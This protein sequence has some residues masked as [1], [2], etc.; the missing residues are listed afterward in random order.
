MKTERIQMVTKSFS[1]LFC[2]FM[3]VLALLPAL[4]FAEAKPKLNEQL[5]QAA[6]K[7]DLAEVR[8]LLTKGANVNAKGAHGRTVL[9]EA[10]RA[11]RIEPT[12]RWA[13]ER[14]L[15]EMIGPFPAGYAPFDRPDLY[16]FTGIRWMTPVGLDDFRELLPSKDAFTNSGGILEDWTLIDSA[17][18]GY[19]DV[20]DLLL[21]KGA[22]INAKDHD[23]RT[24]LTFAV[25]KGHEPLVAQLVCCSGAEVNARDLDDRTALMEAAWAGHQGIA[26]WLVEWEAHVN[27]EDKYGKTALHSAVE[28]GHIDMAKLLLDK[29]ADVNAMQDDGWSA[30]RTAVMRDDV[31]MVELLRAHGANDMTLSI[32]AMLGDTKEI[33]RLLDA[34]ADVNA[35]KERGRTAFLWAAMAGKTEAVKLLLVK[36]AD[37]NSSSPTGTTALMH[38]VDNGQI[39]LVRLFLAKG[40]SVN[41]SDSEGMTA[42]MVAMRQPHLGIVNFL[43]E[44]GADVSLRNAGHRTAWQ[45]VC[46]RGHKEIEEAL[47]AEGAKV[48]P[49][50]VYI[51]RDGLNFVK[52]PQTVPV[53]G[54]PRPKSRHQ[55]IRLDF[56][57]VTI[58]P[59]SDD[60]EVDAVFH[61]LN[62]G[63]TTTEWIGFPFRDDTDSEIHWFTMWV[64]GRKVGVS[65]E[66]FCSYNGSVGSDNFLPG[67]RCFEQRLTFP[68][69][70]R[71]IVRVSYRAGYSNDFG[72]SMRYLYGTSSLWKGAIGRSVF[73]ID[74]SSIGG[75]RRIHARLKPKTPASKQTTRNAV[76]YEIRNFKPDPA[77]EITIAVKPAGWYV[78]CA[79]LAPRALERLSGERSQGPK[80]VS[81]K[82][83]SRVA[84]VGSVSLGSALSPF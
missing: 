77:S 12:S 70:K 19:L 46:S 40:A 72:V 21:D 43:L 59:G 14:S 5:I 29:G 26:T 51:A 53:C 17:G 47:K 23:G 18:S 9:M 65:E 45:M 4:C 58:R 3:A 10:V 64:D 16:D 44:K 67:V 66:P 38:A 20:I 30:T 81:R 33:N 41:A 27:A 60:Y 78:E 71:T 48:E 11:F 52:E 24:A 25:G 31:R 37:V 2:A 82:Q 50:W 13:I 68:G 75:T 39:E 57:E 83:P 34:G 69:R 76:R 79:S 28:G 15:F 56:Q 62:S 32:A 36:G 55:N 84:Q 49:P 61:F 54:S 35:T 8:T 6:Q 22:D 63:E 7:G 80:K 42:L 73:I 74:G 1:I